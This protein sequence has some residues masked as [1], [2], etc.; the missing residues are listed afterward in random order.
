MKLS[1]WYGKAKP[2]VAIGKNQCNLLAFAEK[3]PCWHTFKND[4]ATID[5]IRGLEKKGYIEVYNGM[6]KIKYP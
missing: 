3:Y 4:R 6:F 2:M 1:I 5:A